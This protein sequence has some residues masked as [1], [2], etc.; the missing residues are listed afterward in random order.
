[1]PPSRKTIKWIDSNDH[2]GWNH[3][4]PPQVND[5][6]QS[7]AAVNLPA[8]PQNRDSQKSEGQS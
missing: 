3:A 5:R 6:R 2:T 1:M 7:D 4:L 8:G